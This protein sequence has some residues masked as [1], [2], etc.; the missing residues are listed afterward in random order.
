MRQMFDIKFSIADK[1]VEL[2]GRIRRAWLISLFFSH[3][4]VIRFR[5][6]FNFMDPGCP[7]VRKSLDLE[8]VLL[9]RVHSDD[10]PEKITISDQ[11]EKSFIFA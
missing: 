1:T 2:K 11:Y 5:T 6:D 7:Q 3:N 8:T 4:S 10:K 9:Y